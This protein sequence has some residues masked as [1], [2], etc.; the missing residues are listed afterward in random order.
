MGNRTGLRAKGGASVHSEVSMSD[1]KIERA[2]KLGKDEAKKR[3]LALEP[4]LKEKYGVSLDWQADGNAKVKGTGVSGNLELGA[5][6]LTL[7]L[8]LGLLLKA[9][10]GKIRG[11]LEHQLD[12]ALV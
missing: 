7:E 11:A 5:D 3:L 8:K 12:K 4:K 10:S 2:H 1:I 9:M 6:K